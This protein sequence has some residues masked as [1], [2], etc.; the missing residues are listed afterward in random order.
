MILAL[1]KQQK[2]IQIKLHQSNLRKIAHFDESRRKFL[3]TH[4]AHLIHYPDGSPPISHIMTI[5]NAKRREIDAI[6][7]LKSE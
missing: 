5:A 2:A 4:H 7:K 3:K 1:T 6:K